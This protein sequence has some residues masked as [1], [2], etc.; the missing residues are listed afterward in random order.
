MWRK[1]STGSGPRSLVP[2][3]VRTVESIRSLALLLM[4]KATRYFLSALSQEHVIND[5]FLVSRHAWPFSTYPLVFR[6]LLLAPG[7]LLFGQA[8]RRISSPPAPSG[9]LHSYLPTSG[10]G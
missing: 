6:L 8:G 2:E 7:A 1:D 9:R 3:R 4:L 10:N 5:F